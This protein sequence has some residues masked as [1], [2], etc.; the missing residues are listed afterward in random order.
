M[1]TEAHKTMP[2]REYFGDRPLWTPETYYRIA[3]ASER[4]NI[5][6]GFRSFASFVKGVFKW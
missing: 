5:S 1:K 2:A 4:T 3:T 6:R